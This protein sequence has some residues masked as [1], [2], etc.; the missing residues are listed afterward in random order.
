MYKELGATNL[1]VTTQDIPVVTRTILLDQNSIATSPK[2]I[3]TESKKKLR[4]QVTIE[5]S[6]LRQKPATKNE[7]SVVTK[8]SMLR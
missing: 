8:L 3:V 2:S 4:E 5:N 7:D 1:C 6:K